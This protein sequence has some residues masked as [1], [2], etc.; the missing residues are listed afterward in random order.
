MP[1]FD[2][3]PLWLV[4]KVWWEQDEECTS[5]H[6][7]WLCA[8]PDF[9][10]PVTAFLSRKAAQAE[11]D[12]LELEARA[13]ANPF[14]YDTDLEDR[15]SM[16]EGVFRDWLTD[17]GLEPPIVHQD[18]DWADWWEWHSAGWTEQQR[19]KVWEALDYLHFYLVVKLPP[20]GK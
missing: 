15:T 1:Q 2:D 8:D 19:Q 17:A 7:R 3:K 4:Q 16:P 12:R 13:R 14:C 6:G 5:P 18:Y 9:G 10:E 11:A 20:P